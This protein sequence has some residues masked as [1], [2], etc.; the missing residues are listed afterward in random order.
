MF[1]PLTLEDG[2]TSDVIKDPNR[3]VGRTG[4]IRDCIKALNSNLSLIA[5]YGKRGVGKSSLMRQL[6]QMAIG[7]YA[8]A[9]NAGLTKEIPDKP[10]KYIT[11]YYTCDSM[12][13]ES[14]SL[15]SR[16]CNDQNEEDGLLR[17]VPNDGRELV[18]FNRIKGVH[19]DMDLKLVKWGSS[20]SEGSKY[21]RVVP[22]DIVQ[23]FRNYLSAIVTHQVKNRMGRDSL[24]ILLDEIDVIENKAGIG[25]LIKSLSSDTV[26]FA[27]CGIAD[28]LN[29]IVEDH[30]SV[31]RLLEEGAIHVE[32]MPG[33]E[34]AKIIHTAEILYGNQIG[35]HRTVVEKIVKLSQG[36]PYLTQLIG[37][38]CVNIANQ[39][40]TREVTDA[41][42]D[43]VLNDVKS[44][45]AFPT[46]EKKYQTAIGN[47]EGRQIL[48]H[49][50]AEQNEGDS[51]YDQTLGRVKLKTARN[52]AKDFD[53][54]YVDQLM[55]RL[56]ER[57]YGPVLRRVEERQGAYEFVDPVFRI[58][59]RLR[60]L[61]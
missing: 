59:V 56:I 48:L 51:I 40:E 9:R 41:I 28:N 2:F 49:L 34:S 5:V 11:S 24:L 33:A 43:D 32:P 13:K 23:T 42:F 57:R 35:F 30:A 55:P 53:V 58:Y 10:R 6:Q 4:L 44:G 46:L 3:F 22:N 52:D 18:E 61:Q 60:S 38:E 17:L 27:I 47:S 54:D 7:D 31:E 45:R 37:K 25:S 36:Y 12:I 20:G 14:K 16:L 21:V 8:V 39:K 50:L 26:K 1:K 29:E 15:I 19:G